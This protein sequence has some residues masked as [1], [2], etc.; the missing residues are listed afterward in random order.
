MLFDIQNNVTYQELHSW[1]SMVQE[2]LTPLSGQRV[3][4]SLPVS[5]S[6]FAVYLAARDTVCAVTCA[7]KNIDSIT[8]L[9]NQ[10]DCVAVLMS[11]DPGQGATQILP[12]VWFWWPGQLSTVANHESGIGLLTSGTTGTAKMILIPSQYFEAHFT[13]GTDQTRPRS[14][15]TTWLG[16]PLWTSW[17]L[18][19]AWTVY[20]AGTACVMKEFR[21]GRDT[22]CNALDHCDIVHYGSALFKLAR[23]NQRSQGLIYVSGPNLSHEEKM[24]QA[25]ILGIPVMNQYGSTE[26]SSISCQTQEDWFRPGAGR[27]YLPYRVDNEVLWVKRIINDEWWCMNDLVRVEDDGQITVLG[28]ANTSRVRTAKGIVDLIAA[29]NYLCQTG[30]ANDCEFIINSEQETTQVILIHTAPDDAAIKK[31]LRE[32]NQGVN[33]VDCWIYD[34]EIRR[35]EIGKIQRQYYIDQIEP[36]WQT[37]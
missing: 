13:T 15:Q 1:A 10:W 7:P 9:M 37:L 21:T 33:F 14:H 8:E 31:S 29:Q 17:G 30:L 6:T 19:N 20:R 22:L 23:V 18:Y 26:A 24:R 27:P 12:G 28:R 3:L 5:S 35:N 34:S 4:V 16:L 11:S 36:K 25:D 32:Y 2:L